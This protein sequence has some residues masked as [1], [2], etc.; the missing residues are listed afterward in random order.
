MTDRPLPQVLSSAEGWQVECLLQWCCFRNSE[1]A[2]G[3]V[4]KPGV[5]RGWWSGCFRSGDAAA[6]SCVLRLVSFQQGRCWHLWSFLNI[7]LS[8]CL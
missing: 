7:S 8:A 3:C 4:C 5:C 1:F 6:L 2:V